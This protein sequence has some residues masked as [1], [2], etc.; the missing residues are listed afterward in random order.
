VPSPRRWLC[1]GS[2]SCREL[3]VERPRKIDSFWIRRDVSV[4]R[5]Q[6][7]RHVDVIDDVDRNGISIHVM[8]T[9]PLARTT[10]GNRFSASRPSVRPVPEGC[11]GPFEPRIIVI[12]NNNIDSNNN[13]NN[14]NSNMSLATTT[15]TTTTTIQVCSAAAAA[16]AA[17]WCG[18]TGA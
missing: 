13:N 12:I 15:T 5:D 11:A 6:E 1:G 9:S 2:P 4:E 16:A 3:V 7:I 14:N 8:S 18:L 10:T 17:R